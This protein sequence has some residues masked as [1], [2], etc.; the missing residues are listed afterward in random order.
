M[1]D[2]ALLNSP[3]S[4]HTIA[5]PESRQLD[6]L[7]ALFERRQ[8]SVIR[9]P[10]VSIH[11]SP[12][13]EKIAQ[14]LES[15]CQQTPD[16]LIVLTGEGL[17]RLR[18]AAQRLGMEERFIEALSS[19]QILSRGPKPAR[20]L[21]EMGGPTP[22]PALAPTTDGI[23]GSLSEMDLRGKRLAVQ[24]YG[25]DPNQKLMDYLAGRALAEL[26]TV[27]PYVYADESDAA[28]VVQLIEGLASGEVEMIAFTSKPQLRRL[29]KVAEAH[30]IL[31][32]LRSGMDKTLVAA[33]GPVVGQELHKAG[34]PVSVM[35]QSSFFMKPLVRAAEDA[36]AQ[37]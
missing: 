25:E 28:E 30:D 2:K 37:A 7:A 18:S 26:T 34:F 19:V 11:D 36:F 17:R 21:R 23:I 3:L 32:K 22:T 5:L 24:L 33:I 14:W 29:L 20:A 1:N 10:L 35:P 8:A 12:E 4:G 31:P 15:F 16:M 9:V 27:A 13:Q 6:V